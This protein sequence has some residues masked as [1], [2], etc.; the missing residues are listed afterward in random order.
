MRA[1]RQLLYQALDNALEVQRQA[2]R[3]MGQL[4]QPFPE[5]A[6]LR[7]VPGVGPIGAHL[8]VAYLQEP[9]RFETPQ[10]LFRY[11]RRGLRD[12]SSDGK[13]LGFQPLDR[14]GHGGLKAVS[15]RA[16]LTAT[17]RQNGAVYEFYLA[18]LARTGDPVPARLN[19]QRKGLQTLWAL[20]KT[21]RAF[22]PQTFLGNEAQ[23]AA[24]STCG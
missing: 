12:R 23:P 17:K 16:W 24:K 15:C 13:P 1:Q 6:R 10:A 7:T 14:C 22:D 2:R 19:P 21:Q 4:G 18:S 20:W 11:C 5:I 8:F 3:L 9:T